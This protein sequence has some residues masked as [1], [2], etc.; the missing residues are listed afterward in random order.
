MY[1]NSNYT[2]GYPSTQTGS[3]GQ[4]Q[5]G[6]YSGGYWQPMQQGIQQPTGQSIQ[7]NTGQSVQP[8]GQTIQQ[9]TG[10]PAVQAV[11]QI[12]PARTVEQN[13]E[14]KKAGTVKKLLV[15]AG[16][17]LCFGLF[18]AGGF[19]VVG[20]G[21]GLFDRLKSL[22]T[23]EAGTTNALGEEG[24]ED[25]R[26][27]ID[28]AVQN[29]IQKSE[30]YLE[31]LQ[32]E[33]ATNQIT[34]ITSDVSDMVKAVMPAMVSIENEYV[35]KITYF[36]QTYEEEGLAS[37]SGI[38]VGENET[39]LLIATNYHVIED[40]RKLIVY[41]INDAAVEAVVKGT[42]PDMDLAVI[43]VALADLGKETRDAITIARLGN[44]DR[45]Q[46][47]ERVIA[48]GNA[49]GYGQSVT[50]GYVSALNREI[51]LEDGSTGV[52]IQTDAAINP[53]NSGG[54]LLNISG[55]VVGIPSNKIGDTLIEGMGYAI[56]I[57]AASPILE[58]LMARETRLKVTDGNSGYLGIVPQTVSADGI[59][60][61]G[62][63]EG[64][65]VSQ[66]DEG[67]PAADG[68]IL[69][70]DI[71]TKLDGGRLRTADELRD[72][73]Q[74]Y[75]AGEVITLTVMRNENG[76]YVELTLTVTLG[77]RPE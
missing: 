5:T 22:Q 7:Q 75:H 54:A 28:N 41:F 16:M 33:T 66:V 57:S 39:E 58:E 20:A 48:I 35:E 26:Q 11:E 65:F 68:G 56:P 47:G 23:E 43:A 76:E 14:K 64:V 21:T 63:P 62:M 9:G 25:I 40:A 3:Y 8:A 42:D 10:Q 30:E 36:G 31:S 70:G 52:F 59:E 17:G 69:R 32:G 2:N 4:G 77:S 53:G 61:Y 60:L 51:M 44:S 1:E 55:E 27:M 49:L 24:I 19:Y 29:A 13:K 72:R 46:L 50:G 73:L 45:L 71:I 15:C 12:Q 38:I 37:G 6:V 34:S 74:Y 18:A 67:T